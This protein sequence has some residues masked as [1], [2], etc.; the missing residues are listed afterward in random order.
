M[1]VRCPYDEARSLGSKTVEL[2]VEE[3]PW[4]G[5]AST[6][7]RN[8]P[9]VVEVRIDRHESDLRIAVKKAGGI[10][11]PGQTLWEVSWDAVRTLGIG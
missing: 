6:P 3:A 2:V 11:R 5:R 4:R 8:D 9:D 10:Q 1:C 7:H